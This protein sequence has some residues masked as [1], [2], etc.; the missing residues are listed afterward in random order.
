MTVS[1]AN[2]LYQRQSA[3]EIAR[4]VLAFID[5][6]VAWLEWATQDPTH[7]YHFRDEAEMVAGVQSG[8]HG[9]PIL[10]LPRLGLS[11]GPV[12][13]LAIGAADLRRLARAES[14]AIPPPVDLLNSHDLACGAE[15]EQIPLLLTA[16]G[17]A[18]APVFQTRS[19]TDSVQ[20]LKLLRG[21]DAMA[22]LT[23]EAT[24]FALANANAIPEFGDYLRFYI[25]CVRALDLGAAKPDT[26]AAAI[27]AAVA[28]LLPAVFG[29][30]DGPEVDGLVPPREVEAVIREWLMKGRQV[31]F[32]RASLAVQQIVANGGYAGQSGGELAKL[33]QLFVAR[34][35]RLLSAA[36]VGPGRLAQDGATCTVAFAANGDTADVEISSAGRITI[37]RFGGRAQ[38]A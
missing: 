25:D 38:A 4:L 11:V 3:S 7:H 12:K 28:T 23:G 22:P 34:A 16:L 21:V 14:G 9:T 13:L 33:V 36:K 10:L 15:F 19:L 5:G 6:G 27:E 32:A 29:A 1:V 18:G 2:R 37:S 8:L 24:R 20:L 31:G 30:L 17:V 35:Q 26:R